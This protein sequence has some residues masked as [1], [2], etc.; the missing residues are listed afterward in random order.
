[1]DEQH[2]N[3]VRISHEEN[4]SLWVTIEKLQSVLREILKMKLIDIGNRAGKGRAYGKVGNAY[5]SPG[6]YRKAIDYDEKDLK[7]C[8]RKR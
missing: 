2:G 8:T 5:Q 6:D 4:S 7:N 3:V 1:M